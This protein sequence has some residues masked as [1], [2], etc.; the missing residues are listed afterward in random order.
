MSALIG[1]IV[2]YVVAGKT[3]A[4]VGAALGYTTSNGKLMGLGANKPRPR[5]NGPT[6]GPHNRPM[7]LFRPLPA[8]W[9]GVGP[10]DNPGHYEC[11]STGWKYISDPPKDSFD[12]RHWNN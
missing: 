5:K 6:C 3:G 4:L 11:A 1:G 7:P 2:G 9:D 10:T 8:G 12:P